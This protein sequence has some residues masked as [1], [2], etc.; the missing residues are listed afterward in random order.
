M[1][2]EEVKD[3]NWKSI[4]GPYFLR[5]AHSVHIRVK[6][7]QL[8]YILSH[9]NYTDAIFPFIISSNKRAHSPC[10]LNE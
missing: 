4:S 1:S 8:A 2:L 10:A 7:P 5:F 6:S 3:K 9:V